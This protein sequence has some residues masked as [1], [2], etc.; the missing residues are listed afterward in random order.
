M[1]LRNDEYILSINVIPSSYSRLWRVYGNV[2][3]LIILNYVH[4]KVHKIQKLCLSCCVCVSGYCLNVE[5]YKS[6]AQAKEEAL[7]FS[8]IS[9]IYHLFS[10][11]I[12]TLLN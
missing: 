5:G 10:V 4:D 3:S 1:L 11:D 12:T 7:L 2:P 9:T 6:K 8:Y